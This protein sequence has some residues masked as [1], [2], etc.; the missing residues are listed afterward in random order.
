MNNKVTDKVA[1]IYDCNNM[2]IARKNI[3]RNK[4]NGQSY[5]C[6]NGRFVP[7]H[8]MAAANRCRIE[9]SHTWDTPALV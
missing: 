5:V 3:Y 2:F 7:L 9:I 1:I 4:E 6:M 8:A